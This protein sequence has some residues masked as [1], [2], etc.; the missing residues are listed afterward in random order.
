MQVTPH[1]HMLRLPFTIRISD[2]VVIERFVNSF[3]IDGPAITLVDAGVRGSE[4][5]IF[6]YIR[7]IGRNPEE[8]SLLILT[9]SHPD[10]IGG[11]SAV[12]QATGCRIAAH[13]GERAWIEDVNLQC[14]SR[15]VPGFHSLVGGPVPVDR[16]LED[17]DVLELGAGHT[18]DCVIFHTPGHSQGSIS[19]L[20]RPE[21]VLI[22]GDAVPVPGDIPV[23][24]DPLAS[25]QSV[26]RLLRIEGIRLLLSSWDDPREGICAYQALRE[27]L[28][29]LQQ[30]HAA[31][32]R[33][34]CGSGSDAMNLC[35][36]VAA[37]LNLP[38]QAAT[39]LLARTISAHLPLWDRPDLL[40]GEDG[41]Q[42]PAGG[43][44]TDAGG[45]KLPG[46]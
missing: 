2:D 40:S 26:R 10:H 9:H 11:A 35:R 13:A 46:G 44:D 12:R 37:A 8:I 18:L 23:Y 21:G 17:G 19:L 16:L 38:P 29:G 27:A 6:D 24:D 5:K 32:L 34:A 22:T 15:P 4:E 39:P 36:R 30:V 41:L 45:R 33:N 20:V 42:Q 7:S 43:T 14:T 3:I 25:V 31:V 28:T 1:I